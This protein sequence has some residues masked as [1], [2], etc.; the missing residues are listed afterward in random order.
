MAG[1]GSFN[2][3]AKAYGLEA[4]FLLES[5]AA[6]YGTEHFSYSYRQAGIGQCGFFKEKPR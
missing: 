1:I 3:S 6:L 2:M 5:P 4:S